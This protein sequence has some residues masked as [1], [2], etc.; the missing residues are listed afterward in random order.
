MVRIRQ[1]MTVAHEYVRPKFYCGLHIR[2]KEILCRRS[3]TID[4][5]KGTDTHQS[6]AGAKKG[7]YLSEPAEL[8]SHTSFNIIERT[9]Q[10]MSVIVNGTV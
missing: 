4:L 3:D 2:V 10:Y 5:S 6:H 7:K 1:V 8:L 9:A